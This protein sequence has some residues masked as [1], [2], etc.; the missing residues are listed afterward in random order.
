MT[1]ST[2]ALVVPLVMKNTFKISTSLVGSWT[3]LVAQ[4]VKNLPTFQETR[5]WS[6]G[7]ENPWRKA[8]QPTL[9]FLLGKSPWTE[10]PGGL[11]SIGSHDWSTH[12]QCMFCDRFFNVFV[13]EFWCIFLQGLSIHCGLWIYLHTVEQSSL[14]IPYLCLFH[15]YSFLKV[16]CFML[17]R[18]ANCFSILLLFKEPTF[19][20]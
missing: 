20:F 13:S 16:L 18:L 12:M 15:H 3:S 4:T 17:I 2:I 14:I 19:L 9:V 8:W 7:G 5:V 1:S 11:Q 6:L 10:E